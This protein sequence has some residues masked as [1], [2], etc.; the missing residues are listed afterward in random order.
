MNVKQH[1]KAAHQDHSVLMIERVFF[2]LC[3]YS[4]VIMDTFYHLWELSHPKSAVAF[5]GSSSIILNKDRGF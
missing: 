4:E 1:V 5:I 3:Y 2:V